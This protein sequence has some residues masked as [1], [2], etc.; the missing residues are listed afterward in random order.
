MKLVFLIRIKFFEILNVK[1][2]KINKKNIFLLIKKKRWLKFVKNK[3]KKIKQKY[4]ET[5]LLQEFLKITIKEKKNK[6]RP[7]KITQF[8]LLY[9]ID[10]LIF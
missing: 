4:D 6:S 9:K 5:F 10:G 1:N 8:F 3:I 2:T 7:M